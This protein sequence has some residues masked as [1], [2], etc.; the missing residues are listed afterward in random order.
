MPT[1]TAQLSDPV[2][3]AAVLVAEDDGPSGL[4][5]KS[6]LEGLGCRVTLES[7]GVAALQRAREDPFDLLL[8]DC[9]MPGA[10]ALS[11][12]S[13]LRA[14][15]A[16]AS[17]AAS[18]IATSAELDEG[19]RRQLLLAGFAGALSKPAPL[20]VI[21]AMVGSLLPAVDA[22][23]AP[24]LDDLSALESSGSQDALIALRGLFAKELHRFANELDQLASQPAELAERL[25]RLLASCG[26]CGA[27]AL[28]DAARCLKHPLA[29]G[30]RPSVV[31]ITR[32]REVLMRTLQT[33]DRQA[34]AT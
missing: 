11:I 31:E 4:F 12:L 5:F 1:R 3:H 20:D 23:T 6:V 8:L 26:I 15:P 7:N 18:A 10:G 34:P 2:C 13:T 32:F 30:R 16:A 19:Q 25:H 21:M 28:A 9:R 17:H 14:E 27:V 22:A 29:Q 24:V 33:L